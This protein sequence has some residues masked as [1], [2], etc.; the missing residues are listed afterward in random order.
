MTV[1]PPQLMLSVSPAAA[2]VPARP[3]TTGVPFEASAALMP[4]PP[5]SGIDGDRRRRRRHRVDGHRLAGGVGTDIA[6]GVDDPRLVGEAGAVRRGIGIAPGAGRAGGDIG[7]AGAAVAADLHRLAGAERAVRARHRQ[8]RVVG[9]IVARRGAA[10]GGNGRDRN[11]RRRRRRVDR[12]RGR[13]RVRCW[14]CPLCRSAWPSRR[15]CPGPAP[16]SS[17]AGTVT[18]ALLPEMSAARSV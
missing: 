15:T 4:P 18:V 11:R 2:P 10:V 17:P 5:F 12:H 14:H 8:R 3:T 16:R 13:R 1:W 6:H 9:D 7:P